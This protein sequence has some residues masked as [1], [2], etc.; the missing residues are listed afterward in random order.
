MPFSTCHVIR[1]CHTRFAMSNFV[2]PNTHL[3]AFGTFTEPF[4]MHTMIAVYHGYCQP[5][6][7]NTNG[8]LHIIVHS[9][10]ET[11]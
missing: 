4:N 9:A 11:G 2:G 10:E 1:V 8:I 3:L 5:E 7:I 6:H